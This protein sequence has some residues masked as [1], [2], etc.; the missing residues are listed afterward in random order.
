MSRYIVKKEGFF[1]TLYVAN[2]DY[3][4]RAQTTK[5]E[6]KAY[7]FMTLKHA[8]KIQKA[9]RGSEIIE[10]RDDEPKQVDG[11]IYELTHCKDCAYFDSVSC[12]R[13][14]LTCDPLDFCSRGLLN[15]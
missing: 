12:K 5:E 6:S 2:A 10:L 15:R 9:L 13:T 3:D 7:K 1:G 8:L 11:E 4:K 14:H